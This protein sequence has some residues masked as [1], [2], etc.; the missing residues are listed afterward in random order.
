MFVFLICVSRYSVPRDVAKW[1]YLF[2]GPY[3]SLNKAFVSS[4]SK[5][6]RNMNFTQKSHLY[7]YKTVDSSVQKCNNSYN[8]QRPFS[9]LIIYSS[10]N[11][12]FYNIFTKLFIAFV[13]ILQIFFNFNL[14]VHILQETFQTNLIYIQL[15]KM[16]LSPSTSLLEYTLHHKSTSFLLKILYIYSGPH[17]SLSKWW[18][19]LGQSGLRS[20][21]QWNYMFYTRNDILS[22][23]KSLGNFGWL[24]GY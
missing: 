24:V 14:K 5:I 11:W 2:F 10:V 18:L 23:I 12:K 6:H 17:L 4:S 8:F 15:L 22:N 3:T 1:K 20:L 7:A 19:F 16:S 21:F 13:Y 9:F